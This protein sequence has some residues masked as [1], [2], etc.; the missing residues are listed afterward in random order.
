ML[1]ALRHKVWF[2]SLEFLN[3]RFAY[4]GVGPVWTDR[5][6]FGWLSGLE[7]AAPV[8]LREYDDY[9]GRGGIVPSIEDTSSDAGA[10]YGHETW[11]MLHLFLVGRR[12]EYVCAEFRQ[13]E[14][15]LQAIPGLRHAKFS[16]LGADRHHVPAHRDGFNGVLRVHLALRVPASGECYLEVDGTRVDWQPGKAFVFNPGLRHHVRKTANERRLVLIADFVRPTPPWLYR[17]TERYYSTLA[18]KAEVQDAY[19]RYEDILRNQCAAPH[20]TATRDMQ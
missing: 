4:D 16:V 7:Q 18:A 1:H 10:V 20:D 12:I 5:T 8:I 2:H 9:V 19:R 6:R 15:A 11:D 13:T 14:A 17:R 3:D